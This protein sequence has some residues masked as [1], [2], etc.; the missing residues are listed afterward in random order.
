VAG[1]TIDLVL[2]VDRST[3]RLWRPQEFGRRAARDIDDPLVEPLWTGL[4]I[5]AHVVDGRTEIVD[6]HG[7]EAG[8]RDL[9]QAVADAIEVR[10]AVLDGYLTDDLERQARALPDANDRPSAAGA[11]RQ[12]FFGQRREKPERAILRLV[13]EE[14]T[15]VAPR[16]GSVAFV[17]VDV[18]A[19]DDEPLLDIPLLERKR[20]LESIV[21]AADRVRIGVHVRPPLG[22]WIPTWRDL[23]FQGL[24]F[25]AA[26]SRYTPGQPND[27]WSVAQM[28]TR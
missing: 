9:A 23:G 14:R 27:G 8:G 21:T 11:T 16:S 5:L 3:H 22:S 15:G 25:K 10:S 4:R 17:V 18:L 2:G 12:M 13:D 26:N 6:R 20:L 1:C 24:A 7:E 19:L 28:P